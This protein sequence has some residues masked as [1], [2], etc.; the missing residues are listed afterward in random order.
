MNQA[1]AL[2]RLFYPEMQGQLIQMGTVCETGP[3]AA[4]EDMEP[5]GFAL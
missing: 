4:L 2:R 3:G 1:A 5:P